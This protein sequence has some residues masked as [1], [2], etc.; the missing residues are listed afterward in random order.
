MDQSMTI[1]E[2]ADRSG[3][4]PSALRYYERM[5]LLRATRTVGNQRRYE[6]AELRRVAFIR[7]AQQ[8]G[9]SLE[10]I[11]TALASLPRSRTP[12][13]ADWARLSARWRRRLDDRIALLESLRDNLT[14]CI[15]CGC[16]S[17]RRCRLYNP[18]DRLAVEGRGPRRLLDPQPPG[19]A[20]LDAAVARRVR[21]RR[22]AQV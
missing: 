20:G 21:P 4:A 17:L 8:V 11:R 5:G 10:E 22:P 16:L 2:L 13:R 6:R 12:T 1:G 14:G 3:V 7:I 19:P 9:V 15:G 18:G